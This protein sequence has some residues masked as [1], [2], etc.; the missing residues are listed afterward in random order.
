MADVREGPLRPQQTQSVE[1]T[2]GRLRFS[3]TGQ[4]CADLHQ[5]ADF[6]TVERG[7]VHQQSALSTPSRALRLL[8]VRVAL[9]KNARPVQASRGLPPSVPSIT[10]IPPTTS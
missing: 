9:R 10:G 2:T 7:F 3:G 4:H 6:V 1:N 5:E 8:R